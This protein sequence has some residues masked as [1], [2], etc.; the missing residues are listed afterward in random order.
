MDTHSL[1]TFVALSK[2]KGFS[3]A[4]ESLFI[5]QSTVTK[6]IAA[7]ESEVGSQLFHRDKKHVTLTAEGRIFLSYAERI[8]D[9]EEASI[10]E[11]GAFGKYDGYLRIG[12]TNAIYECHLIPIISSYI[13]PP[14]KNAVNV[15]IGHS[16]DILQ[17]LRDNLLD[18]AFS[19]LPLARAGFIC[20]PFRMDKLVLATGFKNKSHQHGIKKRDLASIDYLMCDFSLQESGQSVRELFPVHSQFSFET[21][22]STKLIPYLLEGAGYS[23]LPLKMIEKHIADKR[24]R[25]IPLLD[26]QTPVNKSFSVYRASMTDKV[27]ELFI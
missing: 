17:M 2:F 27:R 26:F 4:A 9:L 18:V 21:D 1:K 22:N 14:N 23:F 5:T 3:R 8:L 13:A 6:R 12:A 15:K 24:L 10:K 25:V 7:L 19:Y 16:A 20:A 11:M